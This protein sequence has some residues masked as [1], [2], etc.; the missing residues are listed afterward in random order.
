MPVRP[1]AATAGRGP[2]T[3]GRSA[4]RPPERQLETSGL[5]GAARANGP[6][7]LSP[8]LPARGPDTTRTA[9]G[10]T[11]PGL[12]ISRLGSKGTASPSC[13]QILPEGG[14]EGL[15]GN[16]VVEERSLREEERREG[17]RV[18]KNTQYHMILVHNI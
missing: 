13:R 2:A 7:Q 15:G 12:G 14:I 18:Y 10:H 17:L 11:C 4:P 1:L 5:G 3:A 16:M 6:R 9:T 8:R